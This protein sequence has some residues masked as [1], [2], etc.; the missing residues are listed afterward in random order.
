MPKSKVLEFKT[1]EEII[2]TIH[3]GNKENFIVDFKAW[4]DV[5]VNVAQAFKIAQKLAGK[6]TD[7]DVKKISEI[8]GC[9]SM[10]WIDD[11]KHNMSIKFYEKK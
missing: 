9:T 6:P 5:V 2:N 10:K 3:L 8:I 7:F 1:L 4:L 11:G